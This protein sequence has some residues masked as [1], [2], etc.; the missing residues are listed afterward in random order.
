MLAVFVQADTAEQGHIAEASGIHTQ[1]RDALERLAVLVRRQSASHAHKLVVVYGLD[2]IGEQ[3]PARVMSQILKT[4]VWPELPH[5]NG[6][7]DVVPGEDFLPFLAKPEETLAVQ[8]Q[9]SDYCDRKIAVGCALVDVAARH[10][11]NVP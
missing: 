10:S 1:F 5:V 9:T 8:E 11:K 4:P 7:G 3:R 6:T 2:Q